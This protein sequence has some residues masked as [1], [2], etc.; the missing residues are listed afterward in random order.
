MEAAG[1][2]RSPSLYHRLR[3]S[4]DRYRRLEVAGRLF[5]EVVDCLPRPTIG[6]GGRKRRAGDDCVRTVYDHLLKTRKRQKTTD[7]NT[8]STNEST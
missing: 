1:E 7:Q 5:D 3:K 2:Q 8:E 4:V 6:Q